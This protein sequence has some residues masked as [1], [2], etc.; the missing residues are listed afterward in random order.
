MG[1]SL[2]DARYRWRQMTA[3]E[4]EDEL[5]WRR[6]HAHPWHSPTHKDAGEGAY[7]IS[8][9]CFEHRLI[10]GVSPA[11][12]REFADELLE[13]VMSSVDAIEAWCVLPN[14]Y[15]IL[16]R[17]GGIKPLGEVIRRVH[18]WTSHRWNGED[19]CRGRKVWY[20]YLDRVIRGEAHY[21]ASMNYIH[22][23]PVHHGY[24]AN[25]QDW[26]YS[27]AS[28][29]L[30]RVGREE[31]ARVWRAYPVLDYGKEWDDPAM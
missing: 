5:A 30:E 19:A 14:H 2:D 15:H 7:H 17:A 22:H 8:A 29:F 12:M 21:W 11:R 1:S 3:K 28:A 6:D 18:G 13:R 20:N 25:W 4:R 23:N 10:I 16:V 24:A 31:A 26:P 27:S 9:A